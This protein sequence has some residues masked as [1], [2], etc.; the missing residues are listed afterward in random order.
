MRGYL[1]SLL[2][3]NAG[4]PHHGLTGKP[5]PLRPP[6]WPRRLPSPPGPDGEHLQFCFCPPL[7][8]PGGWARP[9]IPTGQSPGS[10][11]EKAPSGGPEHA[12]A[13]P[14]RIPRGLRLRAG[15]AI[16]MPGGGPLCHR[17]GAPRKER[18]AGAW[19]P[20]RPPRC[21]LTRGGEGG[22]CSPRRRGDPQTASP[23]HEVV[24]GPPRPPTH[25]E[26]VFGGA[27]AQ[28]KRAADPRVG[29]PSPQCPT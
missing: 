10:W 28:L 23:S 24:P 3:S 13:V 15:P 14:P 4:T 17:Q 11:V 16:S 6:P 1:R 21:N 8:V 22:R 20:T 7:L 19:P 18:G 29:I 2:A 27:V 26:G 12:D 25:A 9:S 5:T